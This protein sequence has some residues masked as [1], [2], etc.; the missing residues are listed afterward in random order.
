[1]AAIS[2]Q[3]IEY[4]KHLTAVLQPTSRNVSPSFIST[5]TRYSK[6]LRLVVGCWL[7][8][9][10]P[11]ILYILPQYWDESD[12]EHSTSMYYPDILRFHQPVPTPSL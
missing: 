3:N 6:Y 8:T 7:A 4:F 10:H 1:M 11:N 12:R 2:S 5:P 9:N